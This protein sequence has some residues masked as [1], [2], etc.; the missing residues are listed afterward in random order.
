MNLNL[1]TSM[2]NFLPQNSKNNL[3]VIYFFKYRKLPSQIQFKSSDCKQ[4]ETLLFMLKNMSAKRIQS[5]DWESNFVYDLNN[6]IYLIID[7]VFNSVVVLYNNEL[8]SEN[9]NQIKKFILKDTK[10]I[11]IWKKAA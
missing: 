4:V 8:D 11:I 7:T 3:D 10:E 2:A 9:L 1:Q 6:G 5:A